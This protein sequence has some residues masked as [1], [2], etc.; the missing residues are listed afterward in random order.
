MAIVGVQV[1]HQD[2]P[3]LTRVFLNFKERGGGDAHEIEFPSDKFDD[4][5]DSQIDFSGVR[6]SSGREW[7]ELFK[8]AI[9]ELCAL[10]LP[11]KLRRSTK[12]ENAI[13][14]DPRV[15]SNKVGMFSKL[16]SV[17]GESF[18][19]EV[20]VEPKIGWRPF[21]YL[22]LSGESIQLG[23]K[24]GAIEVANSG[25]DFG[26]FLA[27]VFEIEISAAIRGGLFRDYVEIQDEM[28]TIRG[29]AIIAPTSRNL[30][31]GRIRFVNKFEEFLLDSPVNRVL[32]NGILVARTLLSGDGLSQNSLSLILREYFDEVGE[33]LISDLDAQLPPHQKSLAGAHRIAVL[34]SKNILVDTSRNGLIS[35]KGFVIE[36]TPDFVERAF[37]NFISKSVPKGRYQTVKK[38]KSL[39]LDEKSERVWNP[40]VRVSAHDGSFEKS[41]DPDIA[42][43]WID[44]GDIS[45]LNPKDIVGDIKYK[46]SKGELGSPLGLMSQGD[47][48]QVAY[49]LQCFRLSRALV[50]MF[51]TS[52]RNVE[53]LGVSDLISE[54]V[55]FPP[56]R[57][58]F[59]GSGLSQSPIKI[60]VVRFPLGQDTSRMDVRRAGE[61]F[62]LAI[63]TATEDL[64]RDSGL[65]SNEYEG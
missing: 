43:T 18:H 54:I 57:F 65:S 13:E 33:Y 8:T 64:A 40:I 63:G 1:I 60:K 36:N 48:Y 9:D 26:Y 27:K 46:I 11:I 24:A 47:L 28:A 7:R 42:L 35:P 25:I 59:D 51:A 4:E 14:I 12:T 10:D 22:F 3:D 16:I 21:Q 53:M 6:S 2:T 30:L 37:R 52:H 29:R 20:M 38:A 39:L 5:T 19:F 49:F 44:S 23:A 15:G 34:L 50:M 56:S 58:S 17:G 31:R 61:L 62:Q 55:M 32:R 41:I 45:L